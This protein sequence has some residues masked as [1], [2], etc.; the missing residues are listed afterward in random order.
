MCDLTYYVHVQVW[1]TDYTSCEDYTSTQ[2][3]HED[4][5]LQKRQWLWRAFISVL[6]NLIQP[7]FNFQ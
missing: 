7:T 3:H 2:I 4:I 6:T 5:T 1:S